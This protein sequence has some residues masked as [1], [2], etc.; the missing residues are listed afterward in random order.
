MNKID[1][2]LRQP[3]VQFQEH[4]TNLVYIS[5]LPCSDISAVPSKNAVSANTKHSR[6]FH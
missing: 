6:Y 1:N 3:E 5:P 4:F 2:Y